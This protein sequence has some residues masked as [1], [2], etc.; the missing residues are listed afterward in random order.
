MFYT[1]GWQ[2]ILS[3]TGVGTLAGVIVTQV[4]N[5][6]TRHIDAKIR[7]AD[8]QQ[9]REIRDA[10]RQHER[11]VAY[12][13]RIWQAKHDALTRLISACRF[14]KWQAQ[15]T[16]AENTDEKRR[17]AMTIRALDLFRDK[18]GNED[19]ISEITAYASEPV[20]KALDEVLEE[21]NEQRRKHLPALLKLRSIGMQW[22]AVGKEP[23]T[24]TSGAPVA[25]AQ[26]LLQQRSYLFSQREQAHSDIGGA[27]DLDVDWVIDL[28]DRVIDVA[29]QDLEGRYS[30]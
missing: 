1:P 4:F 16:G 6:W 28:C 13:Q 3:A 22:D 25:Q 23:L 24:D 7:D 20:R 29:R 2:A 12:Q 5:V 26:Q 15:L 18:I 21:I 19:G 10:D 11:A 17:R 9:E 27:S 8:R 30:E 14:V